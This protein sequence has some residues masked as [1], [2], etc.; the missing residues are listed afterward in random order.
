MT[1]RLSIFLSTAAKANKNKDKRVRGQLPGQDNPH[2]QGKKQKRGTLA[3]T[4]PRLLWSTLAPATPRSRCGTLAAHRHTH[5]RKQRKGNH[6]T[7]CDT[8]QFG[9]AGNRASYCLRLY[10][11]STH[12]RERKNTSQSMTLAGKERRDKRNRNRKCDT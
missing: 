2:T 10:L 1:V 9:L 8:R 5:E 6:P 4:A 11:R 7:V 3:T 12:T